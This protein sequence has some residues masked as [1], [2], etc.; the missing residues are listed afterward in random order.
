MPVYTPDFQ[1]HV[2][3]GTFLRYPVRNLIFANAE[4]EKL[5]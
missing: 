4:P 2:G 1:V 5:S 3:F